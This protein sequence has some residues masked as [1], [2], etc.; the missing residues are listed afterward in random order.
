MGRSPTRRD[1]VGF[2]ALMT[3]G[4]ISVGAVRPGAEVTPA[5]TAAAPGMGG[6]VAIAG[7]AATDG[8]A[9]GTGGA[10]AGVGVADP[11]LPTAGKGCVAGRAGGRVWCGTG[12]RSSGRSTLPVW[13]N[14][15]AWGLATITRAGGATM[16]PDE[17]ARS[18]AGA[19]VA[20][21]GTGTGAV[22][23]VPERGNGGGV[24][25]TG[26]RT[27]PDA[28]F[29]GKS[30]VVFALGGA[31][32]TGGAEGRGGGAV[33]LG[34][35]VLE[36]LGIGLVTAVDQAGGA[37]VTGTGSI[38]PEVFIGR[39]L[40]AETFGRGVAIFEEAGLRGRGGRLMRSVSRLGAFGSEPS[41]VAES[42][43]MFLFI[44]IS[45]NVQW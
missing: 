33:G 12:S 31:P 43:I 40:A 38:W 2:L 28:G 15:L 20:G 7:G 11:D 18:A 34:L 22:A 6:G 29:C 5:W 13:I 41:G 1:V 19:E 39:V 16:R 8:R 25:N 4:A 35:G 24:P 36:I 17:V 37:L 9:D 21:G 14:T 10:S 42:A 27:G 44:V 32:V 30:G 26:G 3:N 23:G 45:E